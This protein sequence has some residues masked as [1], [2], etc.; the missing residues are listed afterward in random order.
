MIPRMQT[1]RI[2]GNKLLPFPS[3][4]RKSARPGETLVEI[5]LS[6]AHFDSASHAING[7]TR[8]KESK[9]ATLET[10]QKL[11]ARRRETLGVNISAAKLKSF[12]RMISCNG[13]PRTISSQKG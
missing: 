12:K 6:I 9:T 10:E 4:S 3:Q 7:A 1:R 13:N 2:N 5:L 8:R 11:P